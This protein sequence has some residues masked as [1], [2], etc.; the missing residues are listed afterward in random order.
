MAR[1]TEHEENTLGYAS[2]RTSTAPDSAGTQVTSAFTRTLPP[3]RSFPRINDTPSTGK[4]F[5]TP[6]TT[7][8]DTNS[9]WKHLRI[10]PLIPRSATSPTLPPPE[11]TGLSPKP[12][13]GLLSTLRTG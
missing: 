1:V 5:S 8:P 12:H 9:D 6:I 2:A 13:L 10:S 4:Q 7:G 11:A 3:A